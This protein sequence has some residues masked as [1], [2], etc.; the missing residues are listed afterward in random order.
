VRRIVDECYAQARRSLRE[1]RDKLDSIVSQLLARE[2][3]EEKEIYAAAGIDRPLNPKAAEAI[4]KVA[5]EW[6][7]SG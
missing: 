2:T 4:A 6:P 7:V 3:L 5:Y 1:N